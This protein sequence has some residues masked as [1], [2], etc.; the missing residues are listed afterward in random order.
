MVTSAN[1]WIFPFIKS[2]KVQCS[3]SPIGDLYLKLLKLEKNQ[4]NFLS[5]S[6]SNAQQDQW[7]ALTT[8]HLIVH[9]N[10]NHTLLKSF[11]DCAAQ[12]T[13][14]GTFDLSHVNVTGNWGLPF[15]KQ[16]GE[17]LCLTPGLGWVESH[18]Q[19]LIDQGWVRPGDDVD[20]LVPGTKEKKCIDVASAALLSF[21]GA[22]TYGHWITDVWG[23]I[24]MLRWLGL[25]EKVDALLLPRPCPEWMK[26]FLTFLEID[27]SKIIL[28]DWDTEVS[29]RTLL[30]PTVPTHCAGGIIPRDL[31]AIYKRR[32]AFISSF[33]TLFDVDR[34]PVVYLKHTPLTSPPDRLLANGAEVERIVERLGGLVIDPIVTPMWKL[35]SF[36]SKASIVLAQDS[37]ALHNVAFCGAN[38]LIIE[39]EPR[40]NLKHFSFAEMFQSKI[41]VLQAK[42]HGGWM[43]DCA[44]LETVLKHTFTEGEKAIL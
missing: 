5:I 38:M 19:H 31:Y 28:L 8:S 21:P 37:S 20:F 35:V 30:I 11:L 12:Y 4:D 7:Q 6:R 10:R 32:A 24:E 18:A 25:A 40:S 15:F 36:L 2:I 43:I 1:G 33:T 29:A 34:I 14:L 42:L 26:R 27:Q 22:L 41:G 16:T 17:V 13:D 23:R 3:L 39:T 9:D 44:E